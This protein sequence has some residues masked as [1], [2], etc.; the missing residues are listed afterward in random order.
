M[1]GG[2]NAE[3]VPCMTCFGRSVRTSEGLEDD[4]YRCEN[5]HVFGIDWSYDGPPGKPCW[6]PSAEEREAFQSALRRT[7]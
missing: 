3:V 4:Y 6:P 5:G 2:P 1:A 7:P